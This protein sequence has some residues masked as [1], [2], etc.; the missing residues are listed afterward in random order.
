MERAVLLEHLSA[1]Q[2]H[3]ER[4]QSIVDGQKRI[5]AVLKA[6]GR[7]TA[8][9]ETVLRPFEDTQQNHLDHVDRLLDLLDKL[10]LDDE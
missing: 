8:N 6:A 10:P 4:G 7:N 2:R 9:A 1:A 5:L 3:A